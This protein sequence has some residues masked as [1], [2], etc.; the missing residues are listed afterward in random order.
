LGL[1]T[2]IP[3]SLP[4]LSIN[5]FRA[6]IFFVLISDIYGQYRL[7]SWTTDNGLPQNSVTGLTQTPDGYLWF[8][9]NDGLVRFDGN[10]FKIFNKSNTP[11]ITT[12]RL[13]A[14]F[15]DKSG[16]LWFQAEDGAVLY[17]EKGAFIV[18]AE[19]GEPPPGQRSSFF[20]DPAG[21]V[22][23]NNTHRP[24]QLQDGKF[25]PYSVDNLPADSSLLLSDRSGGLLFVFIA[26]DTS[27]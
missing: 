18:V 20:D 4:A 11:Q 10:R 17:Y 23:L 2:N 9:T 14:A 6:L 21:G 3:G 7:D 27:V 15:V 1:S 5:I 26:Y 12:N 13:S 8:T 19:P 24:Y 22:L 16:K 25:V